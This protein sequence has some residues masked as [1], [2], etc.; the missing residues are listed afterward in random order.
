MDISIIPVL[1]RRV[2]CGNIL[3]TRWPGTFGMNDEATTTDA[4]TGS[5]PRI[6][7]WTAIA[8]FAGLLC[9]LAAPL[10]PQAVDALEV[11]YAPFRTVESGCPVC[12]R[13]RTQTSRRGRLVSDVISEN[14]CS[15]WVDSFIGSGHA[16]MWVPASSSNR[17]EWFG[18]YVIACGGGAHSTSLIHRNK[19][20]LGEL[21]AQQLV[22]QY[23]RLLASGALNVYDTDAQYKFF[24]DEGVVEPLE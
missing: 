17:S 1:F 8:I 13:T 5:R 19:Q 15:R 14:D 9:V 11:R 22:K 4:T 10:T 18:S 12:G 24:Q 21:R 2:I 7:P 3:L 20:R 6:K 16:H 23:E